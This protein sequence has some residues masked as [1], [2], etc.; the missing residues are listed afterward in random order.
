MT[1]RKVSRKEVGHVYARVLREGMLLL[2]FLYL[3]VDLM[4][5]EY[6]FV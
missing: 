1:C 3:F 2:P 4:M 6:N 5:N